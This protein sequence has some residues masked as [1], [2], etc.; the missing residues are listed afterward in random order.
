MRQHLEG[1]RR[2]PCPLLTLPLGSLK[3]PPPEEETPRHLGSH[4]AG[5][6]QPPSKAARLL[7]FGTS[8]GTGQL[9]KGPPSAC[10]LSRLSMGHTQTQEDRTGDASRAQGTLSWRLDGGN[11]HQ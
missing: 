9:A 1:P 4:T 11:F 7:P 6:L 3:G 5:P 2:D 8:E 10:G